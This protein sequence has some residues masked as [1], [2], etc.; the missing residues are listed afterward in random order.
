MN[1]LLYKHVLFKDL[2]EYLKRTDYFKGYTETEKAWI[3]NNLGLIGEKD[4]QLAIDN[5]LN[6]VTEVTFEQFQKLINNKELQTGLTYIITDYQAIY[7][8]NDN[9]EYGNTYKLVTTA[10]STNSIL[11]EVIVISNSPKSLSWR[12]FYDSTPVLIKDNIYNK[13]TVTYLEDENFN[14]ANYDF[15]NIKSKY[16]FAFKTDIGEEN[17]SKC[18]EN[19][20]RYASN[21]SFTGSSNYNFVCGNNINIT[22]P[23]SNLYGTANNITI[24]KE[25]PT[26]TINQL[27]CLEDEYYIEYL[28]TETLTHQFYAIDTI[29]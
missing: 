4:V 20:I 16:G 14:K 11:S 8:L 24:N 6:K 12:V 17:S 21:I 7:L 29:Q 27:V 3:R 28:D 13:G 5:K 19:D 26:T 9:I 15:K 25:L 22:V 2:Q 1:S 23:V 10:I 18:K